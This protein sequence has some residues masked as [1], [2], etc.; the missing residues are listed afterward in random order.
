MVLDGQAHAGALE[1]WHQRTQR[2]HDLCLRRMMLGRVHYGAQD[3][4]PE[5]PSQLQ[6]DE[7]VFAG[8]AARA[9]LDSD[10]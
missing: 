1:G 4:R 9:E 5:T 7:Q 8:H 10:P 2:G 3:G 6:V